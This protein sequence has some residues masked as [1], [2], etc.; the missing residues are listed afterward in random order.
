MHTRSPSRSSTRRGGLSAVFAAL[1]A[2]CS[3]AAEAPASSPVSGSIT[4]ASGPVRV[5]GQQTKVVPGK[6]VEL[7]RGDLF[8]TQDA[9]ATW[10]SAAGDE[11]QLQPGT[12][13]RDDGVEDGV[14][15]LFVRWGLATAQ[16]SQ[17]TLVGG[18]AGWASV[19]K[20]KKAR[21]IVEVPK[22]RAAQDAHFFAA[23]GTAWI[24]YDTYS[25]GLSQGLG[26]SLSVHPLDRGVLRF[27]TSQQNAADVEIRRT[28]PAGEIV[29]FVP[30]GAIG[31]CS[32]AAPGVTRILNAVDSVPS[33]KFRLNGRFAR[34]QPF[35]AEVAPGSAVTIDASGVSPAAAPESPSRAEG[36]DPPIA[37]LARTKD[38]PGSKLLSGALECVGLSGED[39]VRAGKLSLEVENVSAG[40]LSGLEASVAF[41]DVFAA[42]RTAAETAWTSVPDAA[43][44]AR[45]R[46]DFDI[47]KLGRVARYAMVVRV[48]PK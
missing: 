48:R 11:V 31:A 22:A 40:A 33:A 20:D 38:Q 15:A 1:A 44:G 17:M 24:R 23:E 4:V 26:A 2:L 16:I 32:E 18:A 41:R 14:S 21:V 13:A 29:A 9:S 7:N 46:I 39:D 3:L 43:A 10:R 8:D 47:A 6:P 12:A 42:G 27:R 35:S 30:R 37:T 25:I 19:L 28:V 36:D 45:A 34:T 5:N